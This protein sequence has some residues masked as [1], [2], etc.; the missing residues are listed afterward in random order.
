MVYINPYIANT[1]TWNYAAREDQFAEGAKNGY[2]IKN[3]DGNPY[4]IKSCSI[5]FGTVDLSNADARA[6][7]ENI[8]QKNII[9]EAGAVGWMHDFGEYVPLDSATQDGQ[10]SVDYHN[11][12]PS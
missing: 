6:W 2:F 5:E 4:L 12:F 9:E 10:D 1:T 7:Y 3:K 11:D 8:I